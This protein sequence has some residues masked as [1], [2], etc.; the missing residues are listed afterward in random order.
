MRPAPFFMNKTKA[1]KARI[2]FYPFLINTL[3]A[4]E[5]IVKQYLT[6]YDRFDILMKTENLKKYTVR[7][8]ACQISEFNQIARQMNQPKAK[9]CTQLFKTTAIEAFCQF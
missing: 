8:Y 3:S 1:T 5:T 6:N 2:S 7:R 9:I 4:K